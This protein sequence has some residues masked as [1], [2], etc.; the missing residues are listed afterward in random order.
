MLSTTI[1]STRLYHFQNKKGKSSE[2]YLM[3][4]YDKKSIFLTKKNQNKFS[5]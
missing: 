5:L 4:T 1:V 3:K 2:A